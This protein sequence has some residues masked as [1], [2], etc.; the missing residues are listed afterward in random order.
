MIAGEVASLDWLA[1]HARGRPGKLA[2]VDVG[3]GRRFTYAELNERTDRLAS[4]LAGRFEVGAG[5]RVAVL[6]PNS[7]NIFEAQFACWKLGAIF[8]PLNWRLATPELQ[9]IVGDSTPVVLLYDVAF[10][11]KAAGLRSIR[12]RLGWVATP[13]RP[14]NTKRRW[15]LPLAV[16]TRRRRT[17]CP[18]S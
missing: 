14:T 6:S 17:R 4:V 10:S 3:T 8:V 9:F 7:S 15:P 16:A 11:E 1:H 13:N 5:A 2:V 18:Q 12:H